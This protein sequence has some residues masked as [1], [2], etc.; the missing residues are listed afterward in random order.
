MDSHFRQPF[1]LQNSINKYEMNGYSEFVSFMAN[2]TYDLNG[3][4][5]TRLITDKFSIEEY[6]KWNMTRVAYKKLAS[7]WWDDKKFYKAAQSARNKSP[8]LV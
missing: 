5:V 6:G 8:C 3:I 2:D 7:V 4:L 1:Q